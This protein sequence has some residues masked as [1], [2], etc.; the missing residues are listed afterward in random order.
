M[1]CLQETK[2]EQLD[3]MFLRKFC[4]PSFDKF[5]FS[6]SQGA[7][8]G[9][10]VMFFDGELVFSNNYALSVKFSSTLS[11][12]EWVL[13]NIYGPCTEA[14]KKNICSVVKEHPNA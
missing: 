4:P 2:R 1:I 5:E 12:N 14:E 10:A 8:G 6:P 7:S 3:T 13:T 11:D 9:L